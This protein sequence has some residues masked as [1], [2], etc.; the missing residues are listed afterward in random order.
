MGCANSREK[1][2]A[3]KQTQNPRPRNN[4]YTSD[5]TQPGPNKN[6][7]LL[8]GQ[9]PHIF[10]EP[11]D[12]Q[13][14]VFAL[15]AFNAASKDQLTFRKGEKFQILEQN[16][17]WWKAK[18]L[19]SG[20]EGFIPY[21]YVEEQES[22]ETNDW[23]FTNVNR[24][25]AERY[26]LAPGNKPG[27]FLLRKSETTE[28]CYSMSVRDIKAN[29]SAVVRHYKVRVL[30]DGG[31]YISTRVTFKKMDELIMYYQKTPDGLCRRL[32]KACVRPKAE[33]QWD[34]D[35]WEVSKENIRMLKRL[36]A[37]QF[38]EVWLALYNNTTKVAVKTLKPGSMSVEAF[39]QEANLMKTLRHNRLVR[40]FAVVTKTAPIYIITEFM[41]NGCLLDFLKSPRGRKL[42]LSKL[43]DFGA[44]IA[45]GMAYIEKKNFV[46]RDLRAA[47]ILVSESLLCKIADFGLARVI[48]ENEYS[49]KEG[50]K[51]P[52]KW[53]APEAIHYGSFTIKSDM[54][55]FGI[56]LYEIITYGKIPYT[57]LSNAEVIARV[58]RG[59]RIQQPDTCPKKLYEIMTTCWKEKPEERPT[60]EFMQSIL[61]DYF[62]AT[63]DQYQKQP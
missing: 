28:G 18:S 10:D 59:Y 32:G 25:D 47:N 22:I 7:A 43:T 37:G 26:L 35:A 55:S 23:F 63:E 24:R 13:K 51:F 56:L 33:I 1:K 14:V 8:P 38:G 42:Q 3:L 15:Y 53:T 12:K 27:A 39:L 11:R 41:T 16:G 45:E 9:D 2:D 54:W 60:F 48:E 58:Q 17:D 21:N 20:K 31:F 57:G 5:P 19:T 36:G 34:E 61:E 49:A 6:S 50:A 30:D 46:H 52:I 29:A 62:T 44:Q 40:L 4:R